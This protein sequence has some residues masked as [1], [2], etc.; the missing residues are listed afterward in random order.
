MRHVIPV[1]RIDT[2]TI[3]W[4]H[5]MCHGNFVMSSFQKYV[6]LFIICFYNLPIPKEPWY[7]NTNTKIEQML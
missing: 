6:I 4:R 3:S 5:K 2:D 7:D 1:S